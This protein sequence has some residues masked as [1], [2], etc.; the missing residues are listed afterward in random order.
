MG[1]DTHSGIAFAIYINVS[2]KD[3][4][5]YMAL[6]PSLARR[7]MN[8]G[9][10]FEENSP[11]EGRYANYL[12][13]GHNAVGFVLDFG[14]LYSENARIAYHIRIV[15]GP[16]FAKALLMTLKESTNQYEITYG[17]IPNEA[18]QQR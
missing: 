14:Q 6:C 3:G 1:I 10:D 11:R 15:T 13:V 9:R 17:V 7:L 5:F 12:K 16:V 8:Q 18:D 4:L 2:I